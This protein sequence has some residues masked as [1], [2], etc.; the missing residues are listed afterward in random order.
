MFTIYVDTP[1]GGGSGVCPYATPLNDGIMTAAQ[2]AALAASRS[3]PFGLA[4]SPSPAPV[5]TTDG[6][7]VVVSQLAMPTD[8][9]MLVQVNIAAATP[10][11]SD[12]AVWSTQIAIV[13]AS[14]VYTVSTPSSP[15]GSGSAG[16]SSWRLLCQVTNGVVQLGVS[17]ASATIKWSVC[18]S[19]VYNQQ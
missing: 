1:S 8:G 12:Y 9:I 19:A 17:G 4:F 11:G 7:A 5:T 2:A 14:G 6:N 3:S 10:N 18:A 13:R 16:S 15:P